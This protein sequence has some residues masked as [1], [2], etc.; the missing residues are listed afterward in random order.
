MIPCTVFVARSKIKA[1]TLRSKKI[2]SAGLVREFRDKARG[3]YWV[4]PQLM[5]YPVHRPDAVVNEVNENAFALG[6]VV[7]NAP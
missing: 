5:R 4:T 3:C 7:E 6:P 1:A 2:L